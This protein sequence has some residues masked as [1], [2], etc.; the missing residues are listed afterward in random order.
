MMNP[1][2]TN[3][4]SG[5]NGHRKRSII[6]AL[7]AMAISATLWSVT[8]Y[9]IVASDAEMF[10]EHID[11]PTVLLSRST[12]Q[13]GVEFVASYVRFDLSWSRVT[14][15]LMNLD[16]STVWSGIMLQNPCYQKAL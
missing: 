13:D 2:D 6:R 15:E 14:V 10:Q 5:R 7:A 1:D 9:A 3:D 4:M 12:V 16:T 11:P 8:V